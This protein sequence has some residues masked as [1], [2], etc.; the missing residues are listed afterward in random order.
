[1]TKQRQRLLHPI[2]CKS[3]DFYFITISANFFPAIPFGL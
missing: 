1:M 2:E 3:L